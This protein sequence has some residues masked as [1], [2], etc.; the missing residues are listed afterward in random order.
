MSMAVL[1]AA[2]FALL[3]LGLP[4]WAELWAPGMWIALLAFEMF[5]ILAIEVYFGTTR[6]F[7]G[8]DNR[9]LH[10]P[11]FVGLCLAACLINGFMNFVTFAVVFSAGGQIAQG[12]AAPYW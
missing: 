2:G 6:H 3:G 12:K 11:A 8:P 1:S 4:A 5:T 10:I 9:L 7:R